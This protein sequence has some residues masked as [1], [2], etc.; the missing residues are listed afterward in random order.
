MGSLQ[1][2]PRPSSRHHDR[3]MVLLRCRRLEDAGFAH[4]F[5]ERSADAAGVAHALGITGVVQVKQVHGARVVEASETA[6]NEGA[7][8]VIARAASGRVGVGVRVADC[9]PILAA[10]DASGDVVAI[11][12]GWRGVV[13]G[14]VKE[15]IERLRGRAVLAAIGP[16]IGP[17]CFEVDQDVAEAVTR[18]A[19]A[20]I[21]TR[22]E[23]QK[24]WIDLRAAVRV[25]LC[26]MGVRD[27]NIEDVAGC[28]KH[29]E[30]RFHSFRRDREASGRMLAAILARG[31]A[32]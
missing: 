3:S 27:A 6:G 2:V 4:A 32:S 1:V 30:G 10:D 16:C 14:V 11:H 9:V 8:A 5:A 22:R 31:I 21:V 13:G 7:D 18:A 12:A 24:A 19:G 28:T 26:A 25:Q 20:A 23:G 29:E 15:A 17:C